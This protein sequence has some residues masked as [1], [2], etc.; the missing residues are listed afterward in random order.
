MAEFRFQEQQKA[1]MVLELIEL[2]EVD[3]QSYPLNYYIDAAKD[4]KTVDDALVFLSQECPICFLSYPIHE[5]SYMFCL[6]F[7]FL[8]I[9]YFIIIY[10]YAYYVRVPVDFV[11]RLKCDFPRN[12]TVLLHSTLIRVQKM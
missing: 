3:D 11:Q 10:S 12:C 9:Y 1:K 2:V 8:L 4:F 7:C 5:V 6:F